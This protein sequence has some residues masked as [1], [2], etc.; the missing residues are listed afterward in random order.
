[1]K[2]KTPAQKRV[3]RRLAMSQKAI[4]E[5]LDLDEREVSMVLRGIRQTPH[6]QEALARLANMTVT[7]LFGRLAYTSRGR[8]LNGS[9]GKVASLD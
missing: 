9:R 7:G 4:A 2:T 1:M 8:K 5:T 6:I 3:I